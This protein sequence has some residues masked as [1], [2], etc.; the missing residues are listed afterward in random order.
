[1]AQGRKRGMALAAALVVITCA[2]ARGRPRLLAA[3][4]GPSAERAIGRRLPAPSRPTAVAPDSHLAGGAGQVRPRRAAVTTAAFLASSR[5]TAGPR[6][7]NI[8][9]TC[10]PRV[11]GRENAG[12]LLP[13]TPRRS[14]SCALPGGGDPANCPLTDTPRRNEPCASSGA[15]PADR[16]LAGTP[17]SV[18]CARSP[19]VRTPSAARWHVGSARP[20]IYYSPGWLTYSACYS[21]RLRAELIIRGRARRSTACRYDPEGGVRNA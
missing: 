14:A 6:A 8:P 12:Q 4:A 11:G 2:R 16:P 5:Y 17:G 7:R 13:G 15:N 18:R 3:P 19:A 20:R 1:M 21:L 10:A 9:A